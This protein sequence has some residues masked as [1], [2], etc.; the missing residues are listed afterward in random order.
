[1]HRFEQQHERTKFYTTAGDVTSVSQAHSA[2][3]PRASVSK[4]RLSKLITLHDCLEDRILQVFQT[5]RLSKHKD[6]QYFQRKEHTEKRRKYRCVENWKY[7]FIV[8][9][10]TEFWTSTEVLYTL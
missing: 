4:Q 6:Y 8:L 1:M 7:N 9:E 3:L 5:Q 2:V 10:G